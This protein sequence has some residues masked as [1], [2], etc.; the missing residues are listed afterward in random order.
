MKKNI[1]ETKKK[2]IEVLEG[3]SRA[4]ILAQEYVKAENKLLKELN[5]LVNGGE[6][7]NCDK[8]II[9]EVIA[10]GGEFPEISAYCLNCG[11]YVNGA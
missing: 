5:N 2:I 4:K 10:D 11:G 7:C 6:D 8:R 1:K 3:K 9:I